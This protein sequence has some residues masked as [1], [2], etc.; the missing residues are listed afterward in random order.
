M[1]LTARFVFDG[2]FPFVLLFVFSWLTR[3]RD[4]EIVDKFYAKMKTKVQDDPAEDER[5][6]QQSYEEPEKLEN[7]KLFPGSNWEFLK[8]DKEDTVG[9]LLSC[10]AVVVILAIFWIVLNIGS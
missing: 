2:A 9:F 5:A 7:H 1:L 10:V 3:Q 8:W 6:L 4:K